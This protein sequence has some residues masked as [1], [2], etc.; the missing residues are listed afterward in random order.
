MTGQPAGQVDRRRKILIDKPIQGRMVRLIALFVLFSMLL[1]SA[2]IVLGGHK[3]GLEPMKLLISLLL[4]LILVLIGVVYIGL[5]F[6]QKIVGPIY[7]FAR[8][9]Q[10]IQQ[11]DYTN[12]VH[13]RHG[14]E[15]QNMTGV[16]N[17]ALEALRNRTLE[18]IRFTEEITTEIAKL[19]IQDEKSKESII[20]LI[21]DYRSAKERHITKKS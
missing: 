10:L 2:M 8:N 1:F 12:E 17:L 20:L 21:R 5:R 18:D 11:G 7:N 9:L 6:S 3:T 19:S 15:F 14:D 4:A 13:L 16:F